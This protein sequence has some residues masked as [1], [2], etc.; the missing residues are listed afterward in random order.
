MEQKGGKR[1]NKMKSIQE[2]NKKAIGTTV[3]QFLS[4]DWIFTKWYEK[5]IVWLCVLW[6]AYSLVRLFF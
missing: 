6:S 2:Y 4:Y 1:N 5:I 3:R